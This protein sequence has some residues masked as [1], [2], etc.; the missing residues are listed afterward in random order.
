VF[1]DR[2]FE[3]A[4]DEEAGRRRWVVFLRDLA[5]ATFERAIEALPVPGPRRLR[6]IAVAERILWGA[7]Y[8]NFT[9]LAPNRAE[10]VVD[11]I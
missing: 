7:F 11:A 1:F 5:D 6:A 2:L 8:R 9:E 10:E 3:R 4:D